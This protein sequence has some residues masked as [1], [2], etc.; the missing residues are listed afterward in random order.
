[1][2]EVP[3]RS[4]EYT[5]TVPRNVENYWQTELKQDFVYVFQTE[6]NKISSFA[7]SKAVAQSV[8]PCLFV[9][10]DQDIDPVAACKCITL[11]Y[12][13]E[14][15]KQQMSVC[16]AKEVNE[17]E[18][19]SKIQVSRDHRWVIFTPISRL[20]YDKTIVVKVGPNIPSLEGPLLS[21]AIG[22]YSFRTC[23]E[24]RVEGEENYRFLCS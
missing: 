21:D 10:F 7:T 5:V 22:E 8:L 1:M 11:E 19:L 3:C 13:V 14:K 17:T 23:K 24:F 16:V 12:N 18:I 6:C 15:K 20:P 9:S 2:N 4:T